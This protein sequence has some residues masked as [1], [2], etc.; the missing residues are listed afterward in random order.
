[1]DAQVRKSRP[2]ITYSSEPNSHLAKS[3]RDAGQCRNYWL[4]I[5]KLVPQ[6]QLATALGFLI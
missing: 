4:Q 5:E 1:M 3:V 6:P 2:V